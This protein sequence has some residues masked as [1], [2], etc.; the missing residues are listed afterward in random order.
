VKG[1]WLGSTATL[2]DQMRTARHIELD[3]YVLRNTRLINALEVASDRGADVHVRFG[4]PSKAS[5]RCSNLAAK[6]ELESH[7]VEVSIEPGYGPDA[8]HA[9]IATV[10]GV[11]FKDD[12]NW[13]TGEWETVLVDETRH[14]NRN[15]AITKSDALAR[16]ASLIRSGK[17]HDILISTESI[18]R[19]PIVE[20]LI[21]RAKRGDHI[22][23]VY[24]PHL[25][26]V[27]RDDALRRMRAAGISIR[28]SDADHKICVVGSRA[29]IGSANATAG[30][31]EMREWGETVGADIAAQLRQ[32]LEHVWAMAK[33]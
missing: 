12:R 9:K 30:S 4:D 15:D 33:R 29:W 13:T 18:G 14:R 31:P 8:I 2:I 5:Q 25:D 19:G 23:L 6:R 32:T 27:G 1:V 20:A 11:V 16:E 26:D 24:K 22:R 17:G 3:T 7:A 28:Q 21:A 10:D